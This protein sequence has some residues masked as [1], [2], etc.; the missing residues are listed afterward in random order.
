[1]KTKAAYDQQR[2][3]EGF[4]FGWSSVLGYRVVLMIPNCEI[5]TDKSPFEHG[6]DQ[7]SSFAEDAEGHSRRTALALS[8]SPCL[9]TRL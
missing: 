5:P 1:M 4:V 2:F 9:A 6:Y 8:Q 7:A 3:A